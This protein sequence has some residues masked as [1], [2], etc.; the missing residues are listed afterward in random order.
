M[1]SPQSDDKFSTVHPSIGWGVHERSQKVR[2]CVRTR[3][4][5]T[6]CCVVRYYFTSRPHFLSAHHPG[7]DLIPCSHNVLITSALLTQKFMG[8]LCEHT[9]RTAASH[10][11]TQ[12]LAHAERSPPDYRRR[13]TRC[14]LL[15]RPWKAG[16]Q[17]RR[18]I[19]RGQPARFGRTSQSPT[20]H[21]PAH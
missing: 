10:R 19:L 16:C 2:C 14:W 8:K 5:R 7:V 15:R 20:N 17:R 9:R 13:T 4:N 12:H 1:E 11:T 3:R 21:I 18:P 6:R